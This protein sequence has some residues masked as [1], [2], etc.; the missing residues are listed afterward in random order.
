[1][2]TWTLLM[3]MDVSDTEHLESTYLDKWMDAWMRKKNSNRTLNI[4]AWVTQEGWR[5]WQRQKGQKKE[6][7]WGWKERKQVISTSGS[8]KPFC[9]W[10]LKHCWFI[11]TLYFRQGMVAIPEFESYPVLSK[12]FVSG[13]KQCVVC[14]SSSLLVL[15]CLESPLQLQR[16]KLATRK[17]NL[18]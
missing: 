4:W 9:F 13:T 11:L 7:D 14:G 1:M 16:L 8:H 17:D 10:T 12:Y 2:R 18:K 3:G 5:H 15:T 6:L